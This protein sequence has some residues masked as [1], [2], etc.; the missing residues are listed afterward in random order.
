V[1]RFFPIDTETRNRQKVR[2]RRRWGLLWLAGLFAFVVFAY[3]GI[4]WSGHWLVLEE[5]LTHVQWA[6][7]LEGQTPDMERTDF[8]LQLQREHKADTLLVMGHRV[9]RNR[10]DADFYLEDM[11]SQ[12]DADLRR[13]YLLKHDDNS[14]FEEAF[15]VIPILKLRGLDTVLLVTRGATTRRVNTVFNALS[16]GHPVFITVNLE[17]DSFSP[18]TWIH[19]REARKIWMREWVSYLESKVELLF[20]DTVPVIAGKTY[21]MQW[22]G[23][24]IADDE[25]LTPMPS[26]SSVQDESSSSQT[27]S[28]SS[29]SETA[30]VSSFEA[31]EF[32]QSS[33]AK[34][35]MKKSSVA[36][37]KIVASVKS[38]SGSSK[39]P[40][41]ASKKAPANTKIVKKSSSSKHN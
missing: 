3:I 16:G 20:T 5:P 36:E 12:G 31:P 22:A 19:T 18:S 39:R 6:V 32:K 21:P 17:D 30:A 37:K 41:S 15:S 26:I 34:A 24:P 23:G 38:S 2:V 4:R 33:S 29:L 27:L 1:S 13:I 40:S 35:E 28:S 7:I 14:N 8:G 25:A 11:R 10:N 9:F